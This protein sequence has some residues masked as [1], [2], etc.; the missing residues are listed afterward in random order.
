MSAQQD[1]FPTWRYSNP[2]DSRSRPS[3]AARNGL[4]YPS[5]VPFTAIRGTAAADVINCRCLPIAIDRWSWR[6]LRAAGARLAD[7]YSEPAALALAR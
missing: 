6:A 7:G 1:L 5:S 4:Y 3:H 2:D